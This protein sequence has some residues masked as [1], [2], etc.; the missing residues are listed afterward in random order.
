ML[1]NRQFSPCFV[2]LGAKG[3]ILLATTQFMPQL[4][5]VDFGYTATWAGLVLS[6]GGLVTVGMMFAVGQLSRFAQPKYLIATGA[7][8]LRKVKL[9]GAAP[10]GH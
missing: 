6:S 10:A 4:V 7:A 1:D 5:Q 3:A 2:V 8:I 9:G